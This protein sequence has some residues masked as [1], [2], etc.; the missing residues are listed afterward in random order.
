MAV[1]PDGARTCFTKGG[2]PVI[3]MVANVLN[4]TTTFQYDKPNQLPR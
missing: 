2:V 3:N 1:W 4:Q